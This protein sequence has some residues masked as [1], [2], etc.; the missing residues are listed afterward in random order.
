[1]KV[2]NAK[3]VK[4]NL[5]TL[6]NHKTMTGLSQ[7]SKMLL[8]QEAFINNIT[9]LTTKIPS[10]SFKEIID[11][12]L[13]QNFKDQYEYDFGNDSQD[14]FDNFETFSI[15]V[16]PNDYQVDLELKVEYEIKRSELVND[17]RFSIDEMTV[18]NDQGKKIV[19]DSFQCKLIKDAVETKNFQA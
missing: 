7:Q 6:N 16:Q 18:Y 19:L 10:E 2:W 5:K 12:L 14:V 4:M 9:G 11:D 13:K 1:M 8:I 3:T 17:V 15:S